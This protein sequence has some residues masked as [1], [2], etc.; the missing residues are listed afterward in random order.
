MASLAIAELV[1]TLMIS[2]VFHSV[3]KEQSRS[4]EVVNARMTGRPCFQGTV[5]CFN[6]LSQAGSVPGN[7]SAPP[8]L[9]T[10]KIGLL[11]EDILGFL[12]SSSSFSTFLLFDLVCSQKTGMDEAKTV[13]PHVQWLKR[14]LVSVPGFSLNTTTQ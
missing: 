11:P 5:P 2:A 13:I 1:S 9:L 3:E 14:L 8:P 7:V 10:A 12:V 6:A 4:A